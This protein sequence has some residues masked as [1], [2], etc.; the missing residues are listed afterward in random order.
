MA[1]ALRPALLRHTGRSAICLSKVQNIAQ[2]RHLTT[3]NRFLKVLDEVQDALRSGKPVVALE[4]TIYTHGF[5][6]PENVALA[7]LLESV[8][9]VNG[10]IPATIGV[11]D[12]VARVGMET[13]DLIRLTESAGNKNT[14]KI[15]RRD[16][17][18]ACGSSVRDKKLNGGTTIAGTALLAHLAGIKIFA[19]GGLGGVHKGG[20]TSMDVSADLVEL[21]RTPVAVI[22]SGCKSFLDIP[23]TLEYLETQGV[24]VGTFA[25][26]REGSVDF[27]A[28]WSRESGVRSPFTIQNEAEAAAIVHAQLKLPVSSGLLLANPVPEEASIP[29]PDMDRVIAQAVHEAE[30][31]GITG[32]ANTPFILNKIKELTEGKSVSA[33][34]VLVASNVK[35]G[36]LVAVELEKLELQDDPIFDRKSRQETVNTEEKNPYRANSYF[37]PTIEKTP[38]GI[39]DLGS[40]NSSG[41]DVV[42]AGSIA[43]DL[44]CDYSPLTSSKSNE[45]PVIHTSN[46]AVITQDVGGVGYNLA[47]A[48]HRAG[49]SVQLCSAIADDA[50]GNVALNHLKKRGLSTTGIEI[51]S[52]DTGLRTAQY[53]AVNDTKK[54][55]HLGMADMQII[56]HLSGTFD[57]VWKPSLLH[58]KPS[59]VV[60]DGN[61][62][63]LTLQKW[64]RVGKLSGARVAFEPVSTAKAVRVLGDRTKD[65][66]LGVAPFHNLDLITPNKMELLHI[67]DAAR[68]LEYFEQDDWWQIIDSL[69][70]SSAGSHDLLARITSADLVDS[71]VPQQSIQLLPYM[72]CILTK[73]G[74]E[75]VL[76]T[77]LLRAGDGRLTSPESAPYIVSRNHSESL[78]DIGGIYMRMF[79]PAELIPEDQIVSVNGAGDT[80]LGVITAGLALNSEAKIEDLVDIGQRASVMTLKSN[81]SVSPEVESLRGVL[82]L[83]GSKTK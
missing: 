31:A 36:T 32:S 41:L 51:L 40:T 19:T 3:N 29:K 37:P 35:R 17:A 26:G 64:L 69:N 22:S 72:P 43:I 38:D 9:R 10:G 23:R 48:A 15:S 2:R 67:H 33:N 11:L 79:P 6:Y 61:W 63:I 45:E 78:K 68:E 83:G 25:D 14:R 59:Y 62:D 81:F 42:V 16:L 73:L 1:W 13:E 30:E 54:N 56:E 12:G 60:V 47:L 27:P 5:P 50:F 44:S 74:Q 4:T 7:S 18:F 77:Q 65:S 52:E 49:S 21:G 39:H 28:F 20:E 66:K 58:Q 53:V 34:K 46:P 57:Q 70:L 71:G 75:G 8:V 80:M 24:G 76:L 55:L 82:T